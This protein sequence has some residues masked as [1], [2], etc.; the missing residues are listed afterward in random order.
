MKDAVESVTGKINLDPKKNG[1]G[2]IRPPKGSRRF[3]ILRVGKLKGMGKIGAAAQHNLRERDTAN[4]RP[5]DADHNIHLA[6]AKTAAE[7]LE[8]W[9]ERAPEKVR[10]NA[11]HALEYVVTASPEAMASMGHTTSEAYL[12]DAFAWVQEKHGT[13]NI[14]SAV[15]H[16]DETTPHLQVMLIPIDERG[17]LNARDFVGGKAKLSAM[18]TNFAERVGQNYGLERGIEGSGARH[19]EIRNYYGRVNDNATLSFTAPERVSGGLLGLG[20]E[21]DEDWRERVSEG[22]SA[23]VRA[24]AAHGSEKRRELEHELRETKLR[25]SDT[26]EKLKAERLMVNAMTIAHNIVAHEGEDRPQRIAKFERDY[27]E[28]GVHFTDQVKNTID[29]LLDDMGARGFW[30]IEQERLA[31]EG[32]A[33]DRDPFA[34]YRLRSDSYE[35]ASSAEEHQEVIRL[36]HENTTDAQYDSFRRGDLTAIDHITS[37]EV[38]SRQLLMEVELNNRAIGF[39]MSSEVEN[40]MSDSRDFLKETLGEDRERGYENEL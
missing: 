23:A 25:L 24:A 15:I 5:E 10:T 34:D 11:V 8:L 22:T 2:S 38:F 36:L 26:G 19:D 7:V 31:R 28:R 39:E 40:L 18:Q 4:A 33:D 6:G 20:R 37:D 21:S 9:K 1:G 13:E 30:H 29:D 35:I 16:K 14:L 17:K 32:V 3:A 12:R 27:L